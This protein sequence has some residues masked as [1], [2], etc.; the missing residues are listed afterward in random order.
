MSEGRPTVWPTTPLQVATAAAAGFAVAWLLLSTLQGQGRSL[1]VVGVPG[2]ASVLLI[3]VGIVWM[4]VRTRRQ[5][6]RR[7]DTLDAPTALNRVL[8]GKTSQLAGA[9]LGGAYAALV[10]LAV[11]AWPAP[12]A[13]ERVLHGGAAVAACLVWAVSGWWLERACRIPPDSGD[14]PPGSGDRDD[15]PLS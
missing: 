9:G 4:A 3:T 2:W 11:Q 12:L 1:P 5:V 8:L 6:A 7:R 14:T 13:V 10:W 15:P